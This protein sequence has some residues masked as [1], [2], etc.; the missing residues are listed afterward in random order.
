[1]GKVNLVALLHALSGAAA[2]VAAPCTQ[3]GFLSWVGLV[4]P[5]GLAVFAG[6]MLLFLVSVAYLRRAFLGEVEPVT[7]RLVTEGPYRWVR[8][9]LYLAMFV[10]TLGLALAFRSLCA[11]LIAL[12]V[13]MPTALWRAVLED[14][15]L[16]RR[17]GQ[18]WEDYAARTHAIL[19]F[20]Y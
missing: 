1:M 5:V 13:F 10:A 12:V 19:P 11:L 7:D 20:V 9:P 3:T 17:F 4:K 18:A 14:Q 16:A 6:G 8:H 2:L 15:A